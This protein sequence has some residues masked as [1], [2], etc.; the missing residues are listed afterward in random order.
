MPRAEAHRS[1]HGKIIRGSWLDI[2]KG[3]TER[4]DYRSRLVGKEY[5][6]G[7]DPALYAA[8]HPLEA[9]KLILGYA[10]SHEHGGRHVMLSDVKRAYFH[11]NA[12]RGL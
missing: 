9:L 12:S 6:P 5:N 8:T 2:N 10:S 7:V 1:G 11:G 3:D 4:P